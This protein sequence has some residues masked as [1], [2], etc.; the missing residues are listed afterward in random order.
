MRPHNLRAEFVVS[1][2]VNMAAFG[3]LY[4]AV[5]P[6]LGWQAIELPPALD[7]TSGGGALLIIVLLGGGYI[8][9]E[10][11]AQA[12]FDWPAAGFRREAER[13]YV[14]RLAGLEE[15][16]SD[17]VESPFDTLWEQVFLAAGAAPHPRSVSD[18]GRGASAE[19]RSIS[20][21]PE[22]SVASVGGSLSDPT[23]SEGSSLPADARQAQ[24]SQGPV[25]GAIAQAVLNH[26]ARLAASP[27]LVARDIE[28]RRSN[29]QVFLSVIPAL[30]AGSLAGIIAVCTGRPDGWAL[31]VVALAALAG[32]GTRKLW[33]GAKYQER[34]ATEL[35]LTS[36]F[37]RRWGLL[38]ETTQDG[39]EKPRATFRATG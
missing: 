35:S 5:W 26:L 11:L 3:A 15:T 21:A 4:L 29:R 25:L 18:G 2:A 23:P 22:Q 13:S 17:S 30:A 32:A 38:D 20:T 1:G 33:T 34:I 37:A 28:Y 10:I 39:D 9:G 36:I 31:L 27:D 8:L 12:T 19:L 6:L 16:F 14:Q 7:P 24:K